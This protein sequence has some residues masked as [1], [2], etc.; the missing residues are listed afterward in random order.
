MKAG[1]RNGGEDPLAAFASRKSSAT[2]R[3]LLGMT[4]HMRGVDALGGPRNSPS[5]C[6]G[7]RVGARDEWA[8]G[9]RETELE[10]MALAAPETEA[11]VDGR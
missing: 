2:G 3:G 7:G 1:T 11:A 9:A 8:V 10:V 6:V 5:G 4:A